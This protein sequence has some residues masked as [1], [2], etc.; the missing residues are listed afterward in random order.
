[1]KRDEFEEFETYKAQL[2]G[3]DYGVFIALGCM[4]IGAIIFV[5]ELT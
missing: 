4:A 5:L 3:I 2:Q 1:M